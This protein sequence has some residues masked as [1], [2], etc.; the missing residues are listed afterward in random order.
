MQSNYQM[1][2][3][4]VKDSAQAFTTSWVDLG[5]EIEMRG[6][7]TMGLWI[8]LDINDTL[9]PRIRALAKLDTGGTKEYLF[10]IKSVSASDTKIEANYFEWNADADM[11]TFFDIETGGHVPMIQLQIQC[12]TVGVAAGQ[13]DYCE[14]T[15]TWNS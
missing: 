12:G 2:R 4:V 8:T 14:I 15:K 11:E 5:D 10:Q 1:V 13:I 9:N 6:Y 3:E 7:N